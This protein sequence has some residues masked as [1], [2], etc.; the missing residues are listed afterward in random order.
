MVQIYQTQDS[1]ILQSQL[2]YNLISCERFPKLSLKILGKKLF[3]KMMI[4]D[5]FLQS[6]GYCPQFDS[7]IPELTGK[8][9]LTLMC[10][11]SF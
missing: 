6:I 11:V 3:L 9:L 2:P 10:R 8:E 1:R 4:F 7:I 5:R